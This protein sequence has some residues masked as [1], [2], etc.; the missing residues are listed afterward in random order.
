MRKQKPRA[1]MT[2]LPSPMTP[3]ECDLRGYEFMPLYGQKLFGSRLYTKA[4]RNPRAGLAA[5]KLWWSAWQQCPAGSLPD[6]DDDL[7]M[8]TDFGTDV[9]GWKAVR[10]IA[11]HGFVKC[12]DGRLYHPVL[13][14]HAVEAFDRRR[15]ERERKAKNRAKKDEPDSGSPAS[16]S[17]DVP[18][19]QAEAVPQD[20]PR[21]TT[22]TD[23]SQTAEVPRERR[24][25]DRTGH[26]RKEDAEPSALAQIA[27]RS[28]KEVLWSDGLDLLCHMTGKPPN[29]CRSL[30]GKWLSD[31]QDDCP[32]LLLL[33]HQAQEAKPGGPVAWITKATAGVKAQRE[34]AALPRSGAYESVATAMGRARSQAEADFD[35]RFPTI[36]A[37]DH[38]PSSRPLL[39]LDFSDDDGLTPFGAPR[40]VH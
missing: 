18:R 5:I 26:L 2:D 31:L 23:A 27:P 29:G 39:A 33:L 19:P 28:V 22:R 8:L 6:D 12:S 7:A 20:V 15:K 40:D 35:A 14:I 1:A 24:G 11:L 25:E 9:K 30:M 36:D 38:R 37:D 16:S 10:E 17:E 21:D 13:A 32:R 4:L 3:P 34:R